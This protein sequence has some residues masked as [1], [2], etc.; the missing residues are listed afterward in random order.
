V[1]D[2]VS[3]DG[4]VSKVTGYEVDMK[5]S[6]PSKCSFIWGGGGHHCVQTSFG[7]HQ[8]FYLSRG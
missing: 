2:I 3:Q 1:K 7:S 4:F 6:I 5:D 8:A